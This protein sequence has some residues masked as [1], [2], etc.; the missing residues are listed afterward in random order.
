[1]RYS[2]GTPK[3]YRHE[4]DATTTTSRRESSDWVVAWR[5]VSMSSLTAE[6]F[7]R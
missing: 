2:S 7:L 6:V 4:T 5:N 3:P 1:M